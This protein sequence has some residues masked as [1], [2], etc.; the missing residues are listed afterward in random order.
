MAGKGMKIDMTPLQMTIH[1]VLPEPA[2][3]TSPDSVWIGEVWLDAVESLYARGRSTGMPVR[4]RI[5]HGDGYANARLLVR[6]TGRALGFVEVAVTAQE[7]DFD[8]LHRLTATAASG[9]VVAPPISHRRD[10]TRSVTVVICTRDRTALLKQALQSVLALEFRSL[11]VIVVD[12][13]PASSETRDYILGLTDRR[14]VLVE[15]P[16]PGLSRARNAGLLA[17]TGDVVAFVDDD[18]V[19]DR[20]WLGTLLSGFDRADRVACVSGMVPAGEIR[21]GAQAE[22]DRQ[23]KWSAASTAR[24]FDWNAPPRDVPLFPFAVAEYGTG[25]NFAIDRR[26]VTDLGGFDEKLGVGSTT[27]GG[28]DLDMFFR[29]LRSGFQLVHEPSAIV[30]H[31]H[32]DSDEALRA[33]LHGYGLGLGA[34]LFKIASRPATAWLAMK[35]AVLRAPALVRHLRSPSH[36][37]PLRLLAQGAREYHRAKRFGPVA[38]LIVGVSSRP[39]DAVPYARVVNG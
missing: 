18:G 17:A 16:V 25:A 20:H 21:T 32:R 28:E 11:E 29:I 2:P 27:G 6:A 13:A 33:Q 14:V 10:H 3:P 30:W 4:C 15:E 5:E 7:V 9:A 35:T 34:W 31:R 19:V 39:A 37:V 23:V 1:P 8:A 26:V 24:V 12:N 38:P 22:F 36:P